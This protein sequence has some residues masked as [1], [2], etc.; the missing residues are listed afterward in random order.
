MLRRLF[1]CLLAV[2]LLPAPAH[3]APTVEE[4]AGAMLMVGFRGTKA[5][6]SVVEAVR[7]GRLGGV[8]LFDRDALRAGPRNIVSRKQLASLTSSL[9]EAAPHGLLVAVDQE[10]GRVRR[11]K[12]GLGFFDLPSAEAMGSMGV[13]EVRGLAVRAGREMASLGVNVDLAPVAD[14]RRSR[15]SPGLGDK[16]R[17]FSGDSSRTAALAAAFG[18]GLYEGGVLPALKHFPGLGSAD[19]DSHLHLPDVTAHWDESELLPYRE[20]FRRGWP[21]MVLAAHVYHRGL[22][23]AL[24]SSLSPAVIEGLLRRGLGWDGVVISDDLQMGAVAGGGR[25]LEETVR[26]AVLA[27]NDILLF[28]NNLDYE[29]DLHGR[30]FR[31]VVALVESGEVGRERLERSWRRIQGLKGRL[32]P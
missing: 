32:R 11:L 12:P 9:H 30:A 4:M 19:K 6:A 18:E 16:G 23:A 26:L 3:A 13:D 8:I 14:V 31:A 15:H 21:G 24:P 1:L 20:A 10:G 27:G 22:D 2:F 7:S 25:S 28:G 29:A 17:L 5:P